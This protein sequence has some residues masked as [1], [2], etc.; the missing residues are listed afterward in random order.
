MQRIV[1]EDPMSRSPLILVIASSFLFAC[2]STS[3][4]RNG[5]NGGGNGNGSGGGVGGGGSGDG[6][7]NGADGGSDDNNCGVQNFNLV[8]GSTPDLLIVQ[9]KSG[10]MSFDADDNPLSGSKNPSSKWMQTVT[11]IEQVVQTVT[12]IEWGLLMYSNDGSCGVPSQPEISVGMNTG[13]MIKAT[14]DAATPN[15]S[16]PTTA[17]LKSAVAYF[18]SAV[19]SD[20]HPKYLLLATDGEPNC[21]GAGG[22]GDDAAGAEQAVADAAAAGIHTFVVGI[23]SNTGADAALTQMAMN[24]LE[25]NQTPGQKPY[26]SV[27]SAN[28]LVSVLNKIAG[29]IV[30]CSYQLQSAPMSPDLVTIQGNGKDI[31]RDPNHMNGWDYGPGDLSIN[32]Y[33]AACNDLQSGLITSVSAVYG[34][35]PVS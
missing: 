27:T 29:Q 4:Q 12:T 5:N 16:T 26:Y 10:S 13:A 20:G 30:S 25:P 31:P 22:F 9:D 3:G 11:A 1:L 21:G 33:G 6:G 2:S 28:D 32:F 24:G 23:G 8:K 15:G 17:A 35:P 18:G 34:C 14:L 19:D 7:G